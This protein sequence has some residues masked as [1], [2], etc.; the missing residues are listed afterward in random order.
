MNSYKVIVSSCRESINIQEHAFKLGYSWF[1]NRFVLKNLNKPCFYFDGYYKNITYD[2]IDSF[3]DSNFKKISVEDFL[4]IPSTP[5]VYCINCKHTSFF[6]KI[7][8]VFK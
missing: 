2:D 6:Q 7:I 3:D 8:N 5:K 1:V 4:K